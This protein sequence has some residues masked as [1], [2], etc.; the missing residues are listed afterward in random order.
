MN[1]RRRRRILACLAILVL[2]L[3]GGAL[4]RRFS[5]WRE[6]PVGGGAFL[7][8]PYVQW[9]DDVGGTDLSVLW[10][11]ADREGDWSLDVRSSI[12]DAWRAAEAPVV[13]RYQAPPVKPRRLY[14]ARITGLPRG[15]AFS[16]RVKRTGLPVFEAQAR[17]PKG[18]GQ[19]HRFVA[20]GDGGANSWEQRAIAYQTYRARPD[21]VFITGDLV[22]FKGLMSEYLEKFFPIYNADKASPTTG[23]PL[24]RSTLMLAT[25]GNHDLLERHLDQFPDGL[26]YF[27]VWALPRNGPL[28]EVGAANSPTLLGPEMGRE[29]FL[30]AA[31]DSY[32]RMANYSFD[33]GDVHWTVLDTNPYADWS[34]PALRGWLERDLAAAREKAWRIVAFHQPPFHSSKTHYD[35]QRTR[36][37]A[38]LFEE[39]GVDLVISGHIHNYQRSYPLRFVPEKGNDGRVVGLGGHVKGRWTLDTAFDGK[40]KTKPEGV[41]YLVTGGGGARLYNE[42]QSGEPTTWQEYTAKFVANT[43]SLTIVDVDVAKLSVKQVSAAGEEVDR[44]LVTK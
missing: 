2:L 13:E 36:V 20:F 21:Y 39:Y 11:A 7:V 12:K 41:I 44:F 15:E 4:R 8:A 27:L 38:P 30:K 17:V 9:G 6:V 22:Y 43:H 40:S 5:E 18:A 33:A 25:P 37:L 16:Y 35:E 28:T 23:A 14:R 1:V 10:Q 34:D 42:D 19:P 29:A 24:L 26:A 32:P 31:G 3:V